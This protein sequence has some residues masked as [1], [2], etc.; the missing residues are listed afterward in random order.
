MPHSTLAIL[1]CCLPYFQ[2]GLRSYARRADQ[3][4]EKE[5]KLSWPAS[6]VSQQDSPLTP[7]AQEG[8]DLLASSI[9]IND[10][11]WD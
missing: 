4:Q 6:T 11:A 5:I 1:Q 3:E 7:D 2:S 9:I 10:S 8:S